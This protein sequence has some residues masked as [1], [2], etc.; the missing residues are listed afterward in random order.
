M[1][2]VPPWHDS[3]VPAEP[4]RIRFTFTILY[5]HEKKLDIG[6]GELAQ[7]LAKGGEEELVYSFLI[8][9]GAP[10]FAGESK[11]GRVGTALILRFWT[12]LHASASGGY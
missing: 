1:A 9:K 4:T 11:V 7:T 10:V 5:F 6:I 12:F 8:E 3:I 2:R